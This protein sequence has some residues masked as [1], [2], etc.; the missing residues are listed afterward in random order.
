MNIYYAIATGNTALYGERLAV[1][2][3]FITL[4]SGIATFI[5]CRSFP[6]LLKFLHLPDLMNIKIFQPFYKYH[7]YYWWVFLLALFLHFVTALVH[8]ALPAPGDPDAL[9]HWVILAFGIIALVS[10]VM[11][12]TSCRSFANF[13]GFFLGKNS[14]TINSYKNFY[15]YHSFFWW[16]LITTV[17]GHF[18]SSYVHIRLW[19]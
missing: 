4:V 5:S 11:V 18:G 16:V 13:L 3:G 15:R 19:P 9:I 8:V 17:A 12:L 1:A 2:L 7:A 14:L 10:L 6:G